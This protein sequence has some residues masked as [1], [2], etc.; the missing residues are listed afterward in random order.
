MDGEP[1][2]I[3]REQV[4]EQY[5]KLHWR[6]VRRKLWSAL[7]GRCHCLLNLHDVRPNGR[8]QA[9][10]YAGVREVSLAQ[11]RGSEGRSSDFD[12]DFRPLKTHNQ[13]RWVN[14]AV[15]YRQ[16]V[17]LPP[18]QLVQVGDSYFVRDGHHRIS[19]ART[20][21]QQEIEAEVTVWRGAA[22]PGEAAVTTAAPCAGL[23]TPEPWCSDSGRLLSFPAAHT[24]P[25][26]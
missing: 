26:P 4:R 8:Q 22:S 15:A 16:G 14:M 5:R 1:L 6:A 13:E 7:T 25:R 12:A 23:E 11:I 2:P 19:V 10:S 3:V 17:S 24:S 18:V 21:G 20:L 9:R